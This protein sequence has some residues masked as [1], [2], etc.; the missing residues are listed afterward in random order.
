MDPEYPGHGDSSEHAP[1][2]DFQF[3]Q[4]TPSPPCL[5][6]DGRLTKNLQEDTEAWERTPGCKVGFFGAEAAGRTIIVAGK[7]IVLPDDVYLRSEIS[8]GQCGPDDCP[9]LPL[10]VVQ[11][12]DSL[13]RVSVPT[14]LLYAEVLAP[15]ELNAFDFLK[16]A[17]K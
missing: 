8:V 4:R 5:T 3:I 12:G 16:D 17:L 14:G 6:P 15:G 10:Y 7:N 13:I 2:P 11:R 1:P 9:K